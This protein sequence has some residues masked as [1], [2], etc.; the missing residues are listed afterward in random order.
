MSGKLLKIYISKEKGKRESVKSAKLDT[1]LGLVDDYYSATGDRN[2]QLTILLSE[3]RSEIEQNYKDKGICSKRFHE[4]LLID[5]LGLGDLNIGANIGIGESI[6]EITLIGKRC[7]AEC[8]LV[9]AQNICPLKKGVIFA[10][11]IKS[12]Q[13]KEEDIVNIIN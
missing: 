8:E 13:I 5:R 6:I 10:K 12:G 7:F 3:D 1:N 11:V 9:K 2:R 4:N